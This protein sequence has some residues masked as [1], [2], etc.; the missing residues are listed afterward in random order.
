MRISDKHY[1]WLPVIKGNIS[2]WCI[3]TRGRK[4]CDPDHVLCMKLYFLAYMN[5]IPNNLDHIVRH[6]EFHRNCKEYKYNEQLLSY[7]E[8]L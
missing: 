8:Q 1:G 5:T 2:F 4:L 7:E 3:A 6:S